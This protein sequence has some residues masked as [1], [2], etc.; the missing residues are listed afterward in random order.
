M[1]RN[2]LKQLSISQQKNSKYNKNANHFEENGRN[3]RDKFV[4]VDGVKIRDI[5]VGN[6]RLKTMEVGR[7]LALSYDQTSPF[8]LSP[9]IGGLDL[10]INRGSGLEEV[11]SNGTVPQSATGI[12]RPSFT[13]YSKYRRQL[14]ASPHQQQIGSATL[15]AA[16]RPG[17]RLNTLANME[18]D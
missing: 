15:D 5:I 9:G 1:E 16:D 2:N 4:S 12:S 8:Q 3:A 7:D 17:L 10:N 6:K 18:A 14:A 11:L 13:G